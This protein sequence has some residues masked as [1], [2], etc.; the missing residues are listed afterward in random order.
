[1]PRN[2]LY[3]IICFLLAG[4]KHGGYVPAQGS[5]SVQVAWAGNIQFLTRPMTNDLQRV[6][7]D[8]GEIYYSAFPVGTESSIVKKFII[9]RKKIFLNQFEDELEPYTGKI[10][11]RSHCLVQALDDIIEF[12]SGS[13]SNW[14]SCPD[15]KKPTPYFSRALRQWVA[16]GEL[17]WEITI[18]TRDLTP[19]TLTC[20]PN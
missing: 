11:K 10:I 5:Y 1:M 8:S 19:H 16:C 15:E 6:L 13:G 4:C 9:K 14:S 2:F 7:L 20:V 12:R 3:L 17:I 18:K